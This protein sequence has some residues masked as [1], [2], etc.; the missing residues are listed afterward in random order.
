MILRNAN[1]LIAPLSRGE[2]GSGDETGVE[3]EHLDTRRETLRHGVGQVDDGKLA[4]RVRGSPSWR[5]SATRERPSARCRCQRLTSPSPRGGRSCLPRRRR[6]TKA[7][8]TGSPSSTP[9]SVARMLQGRFVLASTRSGTSSRCRPRGP[10][11][12][13][14]RRPAARWRRPHRPSARPRTTRNA[15]RCT[16][17]P[18]PPRPVQGPDPTRVGRRRAECVRHLA[19]LVP[20]CEEWIAESCRMGELSNHGC[21]DQSAA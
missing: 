2:A 19:T 10:L 6:S 7:A 13:G 9:A 4:R 3:R 11:R 1:R 18:C 12:H 16:P 15:R 20:A 14:R 5:S 21:G 8:S 17:G